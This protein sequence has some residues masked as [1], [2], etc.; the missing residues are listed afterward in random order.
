M[1]E[2]IHNTAR[3]L[4]KVSFSYL[5]QKQSIDSLL[6]TK[7]NNGWSFLHWAVADLDVNKIAEYISNGV[8]FSGLTN[9]NIIPVEALKF[10]KNED[11]PQPC[12]IP[13]NGGGFSPI[14][15]CVFLHKRYMFEDQYSNQG[16]SEKIDQIL[17]MFIK[18]LDSYQNIEDKNGYSF[19][20]YIFIGEN[21]R[22]LSKILS[23]DKE[24]KTLKK[25]KHETAVKIID[26]ILINEKKNATN[27]DLTILETSVEIIKKCILK[28]EVSDKLKINDTPRKMTK[29]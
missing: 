21:F 20:D 2:N 11:N 14:H 25:V 5:I 7:D 19:S 13:Y 3:N 1:H 28:N 6:D 27:L 22:S 26:R 8:S 15:L 12:V 29:I 4:N 9:N 10:K 17:E 16:Y 24:L 23:L 18:E